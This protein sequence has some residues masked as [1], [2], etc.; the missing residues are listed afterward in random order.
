VFLA[1]LCS[2]LALRCLSRSLPS[3]SSA[4]LCLSTSL[5]HQIKELTAAVV[6]TTLITILQ[7]LA[8]SPEQPERNKTHQP[9]ATCIIL[10]LN[11]AK[12]FILYFNDVIVFSIAIIVFV[13]ELEKYGEIFTQ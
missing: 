2:N 13:A 12:L 1:P 6:T 3:F 8:E 7:E 9:M 11:D 5:L 10:N 4:S